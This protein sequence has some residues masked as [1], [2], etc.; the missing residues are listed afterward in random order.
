MRRLA[1]GVLLLA[2]LTLAASAASSGRNPVL[3]TWSATTTCSAQYTAL[4]RWPGL[5]KYALEMVAGNGFIPGVQSPDQLEDRA[6]PCRGA[7]PRK[8][9]HFF[10]KDGRFGSLDWNGQDVDDGTYTLK[11][12]NRIVIA[13]EFPS[14]TFTYA[15]QGKTIRFAPEIPR[16][17]SSFR[18][19]WAVSMAIPGTAWTRR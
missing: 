3:G 4:M 13:K 17:C 10:T 16:G 6:N 5:R 8:H 2:T 19:A 15:V 18:C 11:G 7:V 12:T 1:A 14:V 9:S